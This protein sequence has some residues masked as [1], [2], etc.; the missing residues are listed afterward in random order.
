[1]RPTLA[2]PKRALQTARQLQLVVL[3]AAARH[4]KSAHLCRKTETHFQPPQGKLRGGTTKSCLLLCT[5]AMRPSN[6]HS[7]LHKL[8]IGNL[9]C[10]AFPILSHRF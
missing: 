9:V 5:Q 3:A 4:P 10:N 7:P 6:Q 8:W 1:M 2:A